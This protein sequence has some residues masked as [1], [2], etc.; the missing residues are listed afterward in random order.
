[1]AKRIWLGTVVVLSGSAV[2]GFFYANHQAEQVMV[3]LIEQTNKQYLELSEQGDIPAVQISY[4]EL[5]ANVLSSSYQIRDLTLSIAG[6]GDMLTVGRAN[7]NGVQLDGLADQGSAQISDVHLSPAALQVLPADLA[8]YIAALKLG[9]SYQYQYK[10]STGELSFQ[11]ELTVDKHFSLSYSFALTSVTDL[12][13]FAEELQKLTPEQQQQKAEQA[14]YLPELMKKVA[15]MGVKQGS[16][17]LKNKDFVQQLYAQLAQAQLTADYNTTQQQWVAA[18]QNNP[19][20]PDAI[21]QPLLD[22]LQK[23]EL[24][25]LSFQFEQP[26]TFAAMQDGTAMQGIE[27][28]EDFIKFA[29]LK[30]NA[31]NSSTK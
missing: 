26:P 23:P 30:L 31:N 10:A 17:V 20:L 16:L 29:H 2:A 21:R 24:L 9:L 14:D 15:V 6:M 1:M 8:S 25:E 18:I 11:Q 7:L 4:S 13:H 27:T 3:Q 22:F 5:S 28:A 19:V 12:W